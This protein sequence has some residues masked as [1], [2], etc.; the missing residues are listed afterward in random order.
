[1]AGNNQYGKIQLSVK[2]DKK[3]VSSSLKKVERDVASLANRGKQ[4]ANLGAQ[5]RGL[6]EGVNRFGRRVALAG[7]A[8]KTGLVVA[9]K[10][11]GDFERALSSIKVNIGSKIVKDLDIAP[12]LAKGT[13]TVR[14]T[15]G[16]VNKEYKKLESTF[17]SI[18]RQFPKGPLDV[19]AAGNKL[20]RA[21]LSKSL[22]QG[23]DPKEAAKQSKLLGKRVEAGTGGILRPLVQLSVADTSGAS[24]ERLPKTPSRC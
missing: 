23:L 11:T 1:M 21:G 9:T 12:K 14:Q 13:R 8:I 15:V 6:G 5:L 18:A 16:E 3:G 10:Q 7:A 20:A 2:V 24:L 22:I 4:I 19:A 17:K